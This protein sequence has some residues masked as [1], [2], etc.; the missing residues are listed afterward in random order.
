[1]LKQTSW[2]LAFPVALFACARLLIPWAEGLPSALATVIHYLPYLLLASGLIL[3]LSFNQTRLFLA[4]LLCGLFLA[5][6]LGDVQ[7]TGLLELPQEPLLLHMLAVMQPLFLGLL[8]FGRERG[9]LTMMGLIRLVII[10]VLPL[11]L[12]LLVAHNTALPVA[13]LGMSVL[14]GSIARLT[15]LPDLAVVL[16]GLVLIALLLRLFFWRGGVEGAF[17]G[18]VPGS[19]LVLHSA[20]SPFA[21]QL[22]ACAMFLGVLW[23]IIRSSFYMAYRDELT[24]L[25]ARRAL[26]EQLLKLGRRYS[27]AMLDVDHFKKFNDRYGHDVGDQVLQMVAA[28][29]ARAGGGSRVYRYGGEEFTLVFAGKEADSVTP[30]LEKLRQAIADAEFIVRGKKRPR[31]KPGSSGNKGRMQAAKEK[32]K[33]QITVSIGVADSS[34]PERNADEV[35]KVADQ[36]LYRAKKKGRNR[37]SS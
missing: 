35:I 4:L 7:K 36:A 30:C 6:M 3:S 17:L 16:Y 9:L 25:P 15:M 19:G 5:V 32:K 11:L 26:R 22:Y 29:M 37:V 13:W 31:R 1:M 28:Q 10:L 21:M 20:G 12:L 23:S 2:S 14:P 27:I 8:L 34:G 33:V 24:G 18:L